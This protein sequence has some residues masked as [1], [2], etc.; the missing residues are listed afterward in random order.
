VYLLG[1]PIA[2]WF[3][4]FVILVTPLELAAFFISW[5]RRDEEKCDDR[6]EYTMH[7]GLMWVL[8]AWLLHYVPFFFMSRV[9]Y[10]HHYMPAFL[11]GSIVT[12]LVFEHTV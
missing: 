3:C 10:F 4:A 11:L 5:N 9:L 6:S 1:N 8:L 7:C 2:Y 12:A